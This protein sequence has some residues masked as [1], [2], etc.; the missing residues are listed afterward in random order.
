V[1]YAQAHKI[2]IAILDPYFP[3]DREKCES[4]KTFQQKLQKKFPELLFDFYIQ[5]FTSKE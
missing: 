1:E 3:Q 5:D 2:R 4:Q